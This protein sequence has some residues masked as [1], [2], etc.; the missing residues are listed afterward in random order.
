MIDA[1]Q[2]ENNKNFMC[3]KIYTLCINNHPVLKTYHFEKAIEYGLKKLPI[4]EQTYREKTRKYGKCVSKYEIMVD[5][6][7][8]ENQMYNREWL[9]IQ[10]G[11][12]ELLKGVPTIRHYEQDF[13]TGNV[14][15]LRQK[16]VFKREHEKKKNKRF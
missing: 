7:D 2:Y 9:T 3:K 13:F 4:L 6:N 10:Y 14:R 8:L 11:D 5:I 15:R 1:T 12:A 16:D